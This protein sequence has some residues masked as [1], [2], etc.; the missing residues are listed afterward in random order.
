[1]WDKFGNC[2]TKITEKGFVGK[3]PSFVDKPR[4]S[5]TTEQANKMNHDSL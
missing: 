1:M 2:I 5:L 4:K 3:L